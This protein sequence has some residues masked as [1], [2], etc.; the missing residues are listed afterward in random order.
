MSRSLPPL[1]ALLAFEAAAHSGSFTAA[2]KQL[3]S[4]HYLPVSIEVWC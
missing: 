4:T 2:A 1:N 3:G